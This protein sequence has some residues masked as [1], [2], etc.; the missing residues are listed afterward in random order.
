MKN[1]KIL[2]DCRLKGDGVR[3]AASCVA[4]MHNLALSH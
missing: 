1:G 3:W 2:R 4:H